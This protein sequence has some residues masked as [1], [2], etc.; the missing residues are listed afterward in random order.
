[1]TNQMQGVEVWMIHH[2]TKIQYVQLF[3]LSCINHQCDVSKC[4]PVYG[5]FIVSIQATVTEA[6]QGGCVA[7]VVTGLQLRGGV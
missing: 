7:L 1:M 2:L 4:P 3:T 5:V 6:R